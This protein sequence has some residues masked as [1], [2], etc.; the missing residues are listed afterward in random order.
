MM[1][2]LLPLRLLVVALIVELF[3]LQLTSNDL[4]GE[5]ILTILDYGEPSD[6]RWLSRDLTLPVSL[7]LP[8][9]PRTNLSNW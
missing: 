4:L 7:L 5:S 3:L 2:T 8:S 6:S 1:S 9:I